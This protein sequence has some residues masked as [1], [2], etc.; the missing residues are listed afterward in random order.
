LKQR[1]IRTLRNTAI[2]RKPR[3]KK[4]VQLKIIDAN[5]YA[6]WCEEMANKLKKKA[7]KKQIKKG[8][9][10]QKKRQQSKKRDYRRER[11]RTLST[12]DGDNYELEESIILPIEEESDATNKNENDNNDIERQISEDMQMS[13]ELTRSTRNRQLPIRYR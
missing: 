12:N 4:T 9:T 2:N 11:I 13:V 3:S 1:E 5:T 6:A 10:E 7:N 8:I